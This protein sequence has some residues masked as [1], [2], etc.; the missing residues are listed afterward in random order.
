MERTGRFVPR[1]REQRRGTLKALDTELTIRL[2]KALN[3]NVQILV[4]GNHATAF[5]ER[6]IGCGADFV[7]MGEGEVAFG[8]SWRRCWRAAMSRTCPTLYIAL[9]IGSRATRRRRRP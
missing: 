1:I 6:W 8:G 5:P 4:G 7:V 2:A 9:A 3:P